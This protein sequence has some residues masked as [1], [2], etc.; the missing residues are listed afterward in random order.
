[1]L[2]I[3]FS[4]SYRDNID[5][6]KV[7][8]DPPTAFDIRHVDEYITDDLSVKMIRD[9]DK[10][11]VIGPNLIMSDVLGPIAPSILSGGVKT[12]IMMNKHPDMIFNA[13][14][15]GDNCSSY[16]LEIA[17]TKDI[18]INLRYIMDFDFSDGD[19]IEII[20]DGSIVDNYKDYALKAFYL[21]ED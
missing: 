2:K 17:K 13:T 3:L 7:V 6:Y 19:K 10:S 8:E 20:N 21:L 16:I 4:R 14:H 12:L 5:E 18:T 15:C 11:T 9:I 1:M